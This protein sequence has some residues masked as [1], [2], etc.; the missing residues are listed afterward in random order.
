MP[1]NLPIYSTNWSSWW[2]LTLY[3]SDAH[4]EKHFTKSLLSSH[5]SPWIVFNSSHVHLCF[6]LPVVTM[7]IS[8]QYI[9]C[10]LVMFGNFLHS[11]SGF[12]KPHI[13]GNT[14]STARW[15]F[16][17]GIPRIVQYNKS[18][19]SWKDY[20]ERKSYIQR[21]GHNE[22]RSAAAS[23]KLTARKADVSIWLGHLIS[24]ISFHGWLSMRYDSKYVKVHSSKRFWYTQMLVLKWLN[25]N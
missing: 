10:N 8:E 2:N 11:V 22:S 1:S 23:S 14:L 21:P 25:N 18:S 20:S 7:F 15:A 5:I 24:W 13:I 9:A 16:L 17:F 19:F 12:I 6:R 3:T 4:T